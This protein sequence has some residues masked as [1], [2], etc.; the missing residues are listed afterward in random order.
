MTVALACFAVERARIKAFDIEAAQERLPIVH[1][2]ELAVVA[3]PVL[4]RL[5]KSKGMK[6]P[7]PDAS[8]F[9]F[10]LQ[11]TTGPES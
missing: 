9:K 5:P 7:E 6:P 4:K 8:A 3:L 2:E 1:D 11:K 10:A